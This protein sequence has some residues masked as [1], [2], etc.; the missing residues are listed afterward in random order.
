MLGIQF[1]SLIYLF[2]YL[3]SFIYF[4]KTSE[5]IQ[6]ATSKC[7]ARENWDQQLG[8]TEEVAHWLGV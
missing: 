6:P 3:F 7:N 4:D 2:I 1:I 5:R 8:E